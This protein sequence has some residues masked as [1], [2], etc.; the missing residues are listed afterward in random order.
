LPE[1]DEE[2]AEDFEEVGELI[3]DGCVVEPGDDEE[4]DE[5]ETLEAEDSEAEELD[6]E[7]DGEGGIEKKEPDDETP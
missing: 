5:E 1:D 6:E 4:D 7:V 3:E 2:E